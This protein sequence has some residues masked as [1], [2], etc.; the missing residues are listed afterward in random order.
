VAVKLSEKVKFDDAL[1][2]VEIDGVPVSYDLLL[3]LTQPSQ[4]EHWFRV[5]ARD[6]GGLTVHWRHITG[7]VEP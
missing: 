6:G 3:A 1:Q 5:V 4:P 7:G 2:V